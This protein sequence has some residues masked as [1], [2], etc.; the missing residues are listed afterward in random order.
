MGP[1][2]P[3]TGRGDH[4]QHGGGGPE[5]HTAGILRLMGTRMVPVAPERSGCCPPGHGSAVSSR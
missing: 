4:A 5:T 1:F 2:L 3:G